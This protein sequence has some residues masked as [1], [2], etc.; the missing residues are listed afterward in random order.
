M[1]ISPGK[2]TEK[3]QTYMQKN[4]LTNMAVPWSDF[5]DLAERGSI[6]DAFLN[7]LST[8]MKEKGLLV[9]YGKAVVS[10]GMDYAPPNI[11]H[12]FK[13]TS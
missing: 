4:S 3:I 6:R 1:A 13:K 12:D 5:Y 10:I 2:V 9:S 11:K 8:A 7:E